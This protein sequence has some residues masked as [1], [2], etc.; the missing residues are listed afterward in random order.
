M[1]TGWLIYRKQDIDRNKTYINWFIDEAKQQHINLTLIYRESLTIGLQDNKH[2]VLLNGK[3]VSLPDFAVIRTIEPFL[4][5]QLEQCHV[6][7]FNGPKVAN[8]CNNKILTHLEI[9]QLNIPTVDTYFYK[10]D[11][12]N[13]TP[14][15][16]YPFVV[17]EA[18]GRSGN[19]V[20]FIKN[21]ADWKL[22]LSQLKSNDLVI[23]KS[24]VQLGKDVRVF[25]V[26]KNIIAA[27]L[28]HNEHDFRANYTLGGQAIPY[29]LN[30]YERKMIQK[31]VNH[32]DF[33]LVGI[34]FLIGNNG[35]LLF[36]E[37]E[38]VVGSRILSEATRINLLQK[39]TRHIK[40]HLRLR[41]K[42]N[43]LV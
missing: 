40:E 25:I 24:N 15:L 9:S 42:N 14:P 39:Y 13:M 18:N 33:G 37:I 12:L 20:Y 27:V 8:I 34:D 30:N 3:D 31:V 41:H 29:V 7:T 35:E 17:K 19:Q 38:D 4:Q 36:N 22:C 32:F 43:L 23:Q 10:K 21:S 1:L 16:P 11:L 28:R 26:G 6:K 2:V 5:I